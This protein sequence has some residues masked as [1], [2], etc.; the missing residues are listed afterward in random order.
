[1][2]SFAKSAKRLGK[3]LDAPV[4]IEP[5]LRYG[6]EF[7]LDAFFDLDTER[8]HGMGWTR[9]PWSQIVQ[10]GLFYNLDDE[11][12]DDLVYFIIR[13]DIAHITRLDEK[14]EAEKAKGK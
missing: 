4:N 12:M 3:K 6:L 8:S 2:Q 10:Y 14:R 13:M 9:I 1:M 11:Q 5:I 7:Y